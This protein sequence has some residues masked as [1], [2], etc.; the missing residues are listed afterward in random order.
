MRT[1]TTVHYWRFN[2]GEPRDNPIM[3]PQPRGWRCWVYPEDDNEFD[4][5]MAENCPT[6]D[7]THRF[8]NGNPMH[9]VYISDDAEAMIFAL[10]WL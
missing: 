9:T 1:R 4:Q 10:R 2:D 3:E 8:N 5:W 7:N 6:A